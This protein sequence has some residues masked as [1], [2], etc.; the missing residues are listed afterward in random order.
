MQPPFMDDRNAIISRVSGMKRSSKNKRK[1]E[2]SERKDGP[3]WYQKCCAPS[4]LRRAFVELKNWI[5]RFRVF[6]GRDEM[7]L[8][9][10][11]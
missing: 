11:R 5:S 6:V 9:G 1:C 3:S 2:G 4:L 10:R 7:Q 8:A